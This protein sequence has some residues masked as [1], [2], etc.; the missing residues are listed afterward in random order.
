MCAGLEV[1]VVV[2]SR[3]VSTFRLTG[4][5]DSR[6]R[7]FLVLGG[8][9]HSTIIEITTVDCCSVA[10]TIIPSLPRPRPRP[11][12]SLQAPKRLLETQLNTQYHCIECKEPDPSS[13]NNLA[14]SSRRGFSL[15]FGLYQSRPP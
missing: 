12:A 11:L 8:F 14:D 9:I 13:S 4:T 7:V 3:R 10:A 15:A 5:K 6:V 1:I 2:A